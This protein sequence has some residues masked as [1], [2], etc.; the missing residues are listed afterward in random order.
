MLHMT[1]PVTGIRR[2]SVCEY[3]RPIA[4]CTPAQPADATEAATG[5]LTAH[6]DSE[7]RTAFTA[8]LCQSMPLSAARAAA[9]MFRMA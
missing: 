5:P 2:G 4:G 9:R 7:C 1:A 8:L 6:S 3:P